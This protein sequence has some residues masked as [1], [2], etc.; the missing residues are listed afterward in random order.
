[1]AKPDDRSLSSTSALRD[2]LRD[3]LR[4]A[5]RN[6]GISTQQDWAVKVVTLSRQGPHCV[7]IEL[8]NADVDALAEILR[9]AAELAPGTGRR[10]PNWGF[11]GSSEAAK[12]VGVKPGTIR[13]WTAM[14]GPRQHPFPR[15]ARHEL[16]RNMWRPQ[17]VEKWK[18]EHDLLGGQDREPGDQPAH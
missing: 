17:Q 15:P 9:G 3:R 12:I 18:A 4:E 14:H 6:H 1:M 11:I 10:G 2:K 7:S 5:F 8:T 16:G 13:A